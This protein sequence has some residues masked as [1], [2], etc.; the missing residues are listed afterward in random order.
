[1]NET[2][3]VFTSQETLAT[4]YSRVGVMSLIILLVL[5]VLG[6]RLWQLQIVDGSRLRT[7]SEKNRLR[8]ER[9]QPMRGLMH[10]RTGQVVVDNRP[11]F[12]VLIVPADA[13]EMPLLLHTLARYL[14][15]VKELWK[16]NLPRNPRRPSYEDIVVARDVSWETL[17][18]IEAHQMDLPGVRVEVSSKRYYPAKSVAA[19]LLGYVGEVNNT[20]MEQFAGYRLGDLVGKVGLE[21]AWEEALRGHSG[22][23]QIEIDASGRKLRVLDE[24][25]AQPGRNLVLTLDLELQEEAERALEEVEGALVVLSV[26]TG[27]VLVM[28]NRPA[29]NPNLFA[30][31]IRRSE[32][33]Q[34]LENPLRPLTN[35]V[36]QGQYPPG[37]TFKPIIAAA[38]L[39]EGVITPETQFRCQ[40]GL[41]FGGR[42]F[43][44][45]KRSGHGGVDL[46]QA[47]A[48]SCDVYFYHIGQRLGIQKIAEYARRFGLGRDIHIAF[49][50]AASGIIPDAVWKR[51]RFGTPW[52]A[53]ETL[54]VVIGQGYVTATPLQMAV[55]IAAIANGGTVYRPVFVKQVIG[56]DNTILHTYPSEIVTQVDIRAE[57][58]Q[59]VREGMW[60]VVHGKAGTGEKARLI[61][62]EVAG[63]TGTAQVISGARGSED[64]APRRLRD[65]A[66][67]VAFAP[68]SDP[69]VVVVCLIEHAGKGGG[70]VAAPVVRLV[71]EAYFRLTR[72]SGK[73]GH[74]IRQATHR[75]F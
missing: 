49:G 13:Q 42:M 75:A 65:H 27:E 29:F 66:W 48:Q 55:A 24:V 38:A 1:M 67:F 36:I 30:R 69:E 63:K 33:R 9:L 5:C 20:E 51:D 7:L 41:L 64:D 31:G 68:A 59:A 3:E 25:R 70:A 23:Q 11:S 14:P 47:L 16:G 46:K 12:D 50:P 28:V 40:G 43:G 39:A 58:L 74:G 37:S 18:A 15:D 4:C 53:G 72:N 35:R 8:F 17:V 56:A 19:H 73:E 21:K 32:W 34:L 54:S 52:Y 44:C 60:E 57:H 6:V 71:L 10:D 26:H 22:G 61:D 2:S 45:W 62:I